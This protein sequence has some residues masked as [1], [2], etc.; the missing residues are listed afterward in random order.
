MAPITLQPRGLSYGLLL[1]VTL[2][3][4]L[5]PGALLLAPSERAYAAAGGAALLASLLFAT[6]A[7]DF[8]AAALPQRLPVTLR[9]MV[10]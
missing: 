10:L 3:V 7:W 8:L 4:C 5:A 1:Y 9:V 2:F 6:C